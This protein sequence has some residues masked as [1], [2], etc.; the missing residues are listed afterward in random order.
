[1]KKIKSIHQ[2]KAE[3]KRIKQQRTELEKQIRTNWSELKDSVKPSNLAKEAYGKVLENRTEANLNEGCLLKKTIN[4]G[5][6]LLAKKITDKAG[7]KLGS[8][9]KK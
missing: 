5:I 3:K 8:L 4:Y 6:T 2:L 9:F 1:M 7:Q